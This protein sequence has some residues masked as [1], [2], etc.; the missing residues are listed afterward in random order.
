MI[1]SGSEML[2][3]DISELG[4]KAFH[5]CR[6]TCAG[7]LVPDFFTIKASSF[8]KL[9]ESEGLQH[10]IDS[11]L[12]SLPQDAGHRAVVLQEIRQ[13]IENLTIPSSLVDEVSEVLSHPKY[14]G[15]FLSIRSSIEDEDSVGASFAGQMD[16]FLFQKGVDAVVK[17][18]L[19]CLASAFSDRAIQYRLHKQRPLLGI[20]AAVMVQVMVD[21]DVSGV[22]FTANPVNGCRHE[23]L[24]S[25]SYGLGEGLVSGICQSDDFI[26]NLLDTSIKTKISTKE[27]KVVFDPLKGYGTVEISVDEGIRSKPCLSQDDVCRLGEIGRRI[28]SEYGSPQDIEWTRA[29]DQI[30]ILQ[31]RPITSLP[32]AKDQEVVWDNSNI[33]ESYCGVT[34]PLT[35]TYAC[36]AY[37]EVYSQTLETMKVPNDMRECYDHPL[38]N[39]LGL[40]QGRVY[41]NINHWYQGLL[42]LPSF[43]TNKEDMERMMGL[44]DPVDFITSEEDSFIEKIKKVPRLARIFF[45]LMWKFAQ[46]DRIVGRFEDRF[47]YIYKSFARHNLQRLELTDILSEL[48]R[49]KK[50]INRE[51]GTPIINDF[52][53]MMMNGKVRRRLEK[54]VADVSDLQNRLMAGEQGI[55]S[56]EPT[57]R[58]LAIC[59]AMREH[60]GLVSAMLKNDFADPMNYLRLHYPA[61]FEKCLQYIEDYGDRSMGELKLESVTIRQ[62]PRFMF[63]ILRNYLK[64]PDIS[65]T[66]IGERE[67]QMRLEGETLAFKAMKGLDLFR[68][69]KD[70]KRLRKAVK[71]RE[72]MR[73][74]RTRAFGMVRDIY[75]EIGRQ[76]AINHA[77]ECPRDIFYLTVEEVEAFIEGRSVTANLKALILL[78][79]DEFSS[80]QSQEP[81][82]HF[83]T[84][85]SVYIGNDYTYCGA[86]K[87]A[88]KEGTTKVYGTGCYPGM[89]RKPLRLI[90]QPS[91]KLSLDGQILCTLRTD[92]GWAPLF[93]T[94][95]GLLVER[96]SILSHSAVVARE[97][98]IPAIVGIPGLTKM[99]H[100][101]QVVCMN[102][103]E[104]WLDLSPST[105]VSQTNRHG[106]YFDPSSKGR[107]ACL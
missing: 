72:S 95:G 20:R 78:R 47:S 96:G 99:V 59:E 88:V 107:G 53:V 62:N 46:I 71:Y 100:D 58:L 90:V 87:T 77:I 16:T 74:A 13:D 104:G 57:K 51:W 43:K 17:G 63:S 48:R 38:Q 83:K 76:F 31:T 9:V 66:S 92:P 64:R 29:D 54:N 35:F 70:L 4:G 60:P 67:H 19:K 41:Y 45:F 25:A 37:S 21:G 101:G 11:R 30:W 22:M 55:E 98:G 61:I 3:A 93:P 40:I 33:Q 85:G 65:A 106:A 7:Y 5:L 42:L 44:Q 86:H 89:V 24:I 56:T 75:L 12:L 50:E 52:Y 69:K 27:S 79:K 23:S 94:A 81:A 82:H 34:L 49:L 8:V 84:K 68:F 6:L 32:N 73:M 18:Y 103:Q 39:L 28:S 91:D 10:Y 97:L 80:Y 102:G 14:D 1:L 2:L 15:K 36:K 26:Y 105:T